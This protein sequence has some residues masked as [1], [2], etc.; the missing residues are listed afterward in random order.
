[1]GFASPRS[2]LLIIARS[3][4]RARE[5][6]AGAKYQHDEEREVARENLPFRI[7]ACADRLSDADDHSARKRSPKGS[8]TPRQPL[9]WPRSIKCLR[10]APGTAASPS[11]TSKGKTKGGGLS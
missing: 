8:H 10:P 4:E 9:L 11:A 1:M 2:V 6:A 3:V 7:D 5:E